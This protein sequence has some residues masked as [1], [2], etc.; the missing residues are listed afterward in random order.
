VPHRAPS[1]RA[2]LTIV[3]YG[4]AR[5]RGRFDELPFAERVAAVLATLVVLGLATTLAFDFRARLAARFNTTTRWNTPMAV[6]LS[7]CCFAAPG[8]P[9]AMLASASA[10]LPRA[11]ICSRAPLEL[12]GR[13][14]AESRDRVYLGQPD[15]AGDQKDQRLIV[16]IPFSRI[17]SV[18]I[19]PGAA[20]A[21][22]GCT[23]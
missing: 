19:G 16:S 14:I 12:E 3:L 8:L 10:G 2:R 21:T 13:L 20:S 9:V 23:T 17:E 18:F 6:G 11:Q 1:G 4:I 15:D 7:A 22:A 5:V